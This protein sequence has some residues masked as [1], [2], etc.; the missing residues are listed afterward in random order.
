MSKKKNKNKKTIREGI[1]EINDICMNGIELW[2]HITPEEFGFVQ[3]TK[4]ERSDFWYTTIFE[5]AEDLEEKEIGFSNECYYLDR[6]NEQDKVVLAKKDKFYIVYGVGEVVE[7][8]GFDTDITQIVTN[9]YEEAKKYFDSIEPET[10]NPKDEIREVR[11]KLGE[12]SESIWIDIKDNGYS[13]YYNVKYCNRLI[14]EKAKHLDADLIRQQTE[15]YDNLDKELREKGVTISELYKAPREWNNNQR[16]YLFSFTKGWDEF[17]E[18][19]HIPSK[20][21]NKMRLVLDY[22]KSS[23]LEE[24]AAEAAE[25]LPEEEQQ[26][27]YT[28]PLCGTDHPDGCECKKII[29]CGS[30]VQDR[31]PVQKEDTGADGRCRICGAKEGQ[32]RHIGCVAEHIPGRDIPM[33]KFWMIEQDDDGEVTYIADNGKKW[34]YMLSMEG[35]FLYPFKEIKV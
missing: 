5:D 4:E 33:S 10:Q 20:M 35:S 26:E 19:A 3:E 15:R 27:P 7:N 11:E 6:D 13:V 9:N 14:I 1:T 2:D 12:L 28:C 31:I 16:Y 29:F 30:E 24:I 18:L 34:D 22:Y 23:W 32:M 17:E 8:D 21:Q 25:E